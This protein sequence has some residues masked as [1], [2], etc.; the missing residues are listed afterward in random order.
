MPINK[1]DNILIVVN[2]LEI[3]KKFF[4]GLG[5]SLEGE[6]KISGPLVGKL[7]GLD[8]VES[9]IVMLR[10]PDGSG[11]ELDKFHVPAQE[12]D[13]LKSLPVTELGYRRI[14]LSVSDIDAMI[15]I[16]CSNGASLMG[17]MNYENIYKLAYVCGPEGIIVAF[18]EKLKSKI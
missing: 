5:Y 16:A 8:N 3:V 2:N 4:V 9:T 10:G 13:K 6:S 14:M 1:L 7:I 18:A 12:N 11:I 15:Q 17:E